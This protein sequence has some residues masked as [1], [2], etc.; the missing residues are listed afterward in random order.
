MLSVQYINT[1]FITASN[2]NQISGK[3][4]ESRKY[5]ENVRAILFYLNL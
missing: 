5:L 3:K 1:T 4:V 2:L